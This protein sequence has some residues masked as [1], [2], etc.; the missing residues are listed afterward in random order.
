MYLLEL[1]EGKWEKG[2]SDLV[3]VVYLDDW[4]IAVLC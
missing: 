2:Q 1:S 4:A 3:C